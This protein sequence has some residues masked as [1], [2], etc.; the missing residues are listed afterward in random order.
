MDIRSS[1]I[2]A[3]ILNYISDGKLHTMRDIAIE[4]EVSERTARR[5]IQSLSYRYPIEVFV[6]GRDTGGVKLDTRYIVQG[7]IITNDKL[8]LINKA[9]RLLQK[10]GQDEDQ[11]LLN[12]LIHDFALP[13]NCKEKQNE[14]TH[15]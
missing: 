8:Q 2:T 9:L 15:Q 13:E 4:V 14:I 10:S 7:K 6:G 11:R 3:D 12:E 1:S 5:H